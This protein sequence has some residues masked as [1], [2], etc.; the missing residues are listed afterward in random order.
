MPRVEIHPHAVGRSPE[1]G[2]SEEEI[3]Q[4]VLT[5]QSSPAKFGRTSFRQ[6]FRYDRVWRGCRYANKEV[7]AIAVEIA[8]G[9]LVL[10]A[11]SRYF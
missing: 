9:W 7:E 2:I 3:V 1:R 6:T 8:G 5:G 11:I 4:T 10:T